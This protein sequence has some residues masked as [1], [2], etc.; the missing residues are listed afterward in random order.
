MVA[1]K[2]HCVTRVQVSL[3]T[4]RGEQCDGYEKRRRRH[5]KPFIGLS[6]LGQL[7]FC[8]IQSTISQLAS[9]A[10]YAGAAFADDRSNGVRISSRAELTD[11]QRADAKARLALLN[12]DI[13]GDPLLRRLGGR[14]A[15]SLM[16]AGTMTER[17]HFDF[18]A[19]YVIGCPDA[20]NADAV[21]EFGRSRYP[22]LAI[23]GK[24]VQCNLYAALWQRA[25]GDVLVVSYDGNERVTRTV[26]G[27]VA[28]AERWL[29]RAWTL[30]SGAEAPRAPD[31]SSRCRSCVYNEK[32]GCPFP[33][34][35]RIPELDEM[36]K[37]AARFGS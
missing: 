26:R 32:G 3:I 10:D 35:G 18:G 21:M 5:T 14:A 28:Q 9:Q 24:S 13:A 2:E 23:A 37:V 36:T 12:D 8:E 17:R 16:L 25:R 29:N 30:I 1:A 20:V 7:N 6:D 22:R 11:A 15:E 34:T 31:R 4:L 33:R 27:D 19:F